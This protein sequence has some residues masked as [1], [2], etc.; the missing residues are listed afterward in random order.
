MSSPSLMEKFVEMRGG[1]CLSTWQITLV[2][3][4][5]EAGCWSSPTPKVVDSVLTC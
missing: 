1:N 4:S 2:S 3:A 5:F